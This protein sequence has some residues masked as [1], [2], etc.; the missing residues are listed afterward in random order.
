[1][2]K[3]YPIT[4]GNGVKGETYGAELSANAQV[5]N[6]WNL[7]GGYTFLKKNLWAK[8]GSQDMNKATAESDDPMHQFL[9]QSNVQLPL[10]FQF[11]TVVR[12]VAQLPK[13]VVKAYTGLD[14][15]LGWNYKCLELSV[16]GQNLLYNQHREFH[17]STPVR[18]IPRS[19]YGRIAC[20][21]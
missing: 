7:R 2:G 21:F 17:A 1:M 5:T 19:I 15:K 18:E 12:Y 13:P 6:W 14:L 16:V 10:H 8:E 3:V 20:R 11:G 4:Y 9:I